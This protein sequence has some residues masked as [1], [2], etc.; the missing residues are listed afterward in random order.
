ME[1]RRIVDAEVRRVDLRRP[2]PEHMAE[3]LRG[4]RV[5]RLHR[6]AKYILVDLGSR[7]TLLIHLG[8]SGR[9]LVDMANQAHFHDD[10]APDRRHDHVVLR[11]ETGTQVT[12]ND[13]R[14]FGLM[15]LVA[16][17][18]AEAHPLLA[19]LGPEPFGNAFDE[20]YLV[21]ALSQRR[22]PIKTALLDQRTIAGLGNIYACEVLHRAGL[23]P[24]RRADRIAAGRI[25]GLVPIIRAVLQEAID[26][27]GS[28]LR[29]HRQTNGELGYF[30]HAFQAYGREGEPC[31]TP[32]CD[33]AIRRIVQSG[34]ST[35]YCGKCQR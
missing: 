35:F 25:A 5:L 14:R 11:M 8:M 4:Q 3:R 17:E 23:D 13:A 7:E 6:R 20:S 28:S 12:F 1:G 33:G 21:H 22:S 19:G 26:A 34:R 10:R 27:G 15:D 9:L 18:R 30:Q 29:D 2:F 16:T 31:R 24:T 32:G